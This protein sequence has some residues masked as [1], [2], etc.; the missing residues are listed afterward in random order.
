MSLKSLQKFLLL[1]LM[2]MLL[3]LAVQ[4]AQ[5]GDL[6]TARVAVAS[7]SAA[8]RNTALSNALTQVLIK[9]SG[10]ANIAAVAAIKSK[11]PQAATIVQRYSYYQQQTDNAPPQL[12]LKVDFAPNQIV[13]LLHDAAQ[14]VWSKQRPLL[15]A[16]VSI[17]NGQQSKL[18]SN[19]DALGS[20]LTQDAD[21]RG[22]AIDVPMMDIGDLNAVSLDDVLQV[23]IDKLTAAS[24]RYG[25]GGVLIG[26]ITMQ[27]PQSWQAAWTLS[28]GGQRQA[29]QVTGNSAK[30][31][32]QQGVAAIADSLA[33]RLAIVENANALNSVEIKVSDIRSVAAYDA[34]MGYLQHLTPVKHVSVVVVN[35]DQVTYKLQLISSQQALVQAIAANP[36]MLPLSGDNMPDNNSLQYRW[37]K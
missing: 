3:P 26:Q 23:N 15:I 14:P 31:V 8:E 6:Y 11:L 10:N 7:S 32:L 19:S 37:V 36:G 25:Q 22:L 33:A 20:Q 29:W 9:V 30:A 34:A 2:V 16:W 35:A 24:Q 18:L 13:T 5:I 28:L 27:N 1:S 21:Q 17:N 12:M 4:A